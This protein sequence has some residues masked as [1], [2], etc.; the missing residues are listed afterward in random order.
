[1]SSRKELAIMR[2]APLWLLPC[3]QDIALQH[4]EHLR[5]LTAL[6][7]A[8]GTDNRIAV[9]EYL[10]RDDA[11]VHHPFHRLYMAK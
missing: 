9:G 4:G 7:E 1:M 5:R 6:G 10:P 8:C 3:L 11:V 2:P